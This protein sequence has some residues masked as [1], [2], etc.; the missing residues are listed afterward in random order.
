LHRAYGHLRNTSGG[1]LCEWN[2]CGEKKK[3]PIKTAMPADS[4]LAAYSRSGDFGW[5]RIQGQLQKY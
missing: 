1:R 4:M 3:T 5:S 2:G